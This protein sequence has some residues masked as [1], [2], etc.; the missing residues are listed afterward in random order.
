MPKVYDA[1]QRVA[2]A[3]ESQRRLRRAL[4]DIDGAVVL[5][6][7]AGTGT[8]EAILPTQAQYIWLDTDVEK[9]AGFRTH[10]TSPAILGDATRLPLRDNSVDWAVSAGVSHHLDDDQLERMLDE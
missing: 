3:V 9:L 4:D 10:S 7:G 8:L 6:V 5:D 2:G 1:V